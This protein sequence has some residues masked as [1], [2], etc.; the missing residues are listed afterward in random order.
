MNLREYLRCELIHRA[1]RFAEPSA[2]IIAK[3]WNHK[4]FEIKRNLD[5]MTNESKNTLP[6]HL[7]LVLKIPLKNKMPKV[8]DDD[9]QRKE[10]DCLV[11]DLGL[12]CDEDVVVGHV[13]ISR[14]DGRSD[15]ACCISYSLVVDSK[16]RG[17]GFGRVLTE[18][19]EDR[20]RSLGLSYM[21]LS[22]NDK[23]KMDRFPLQKSKNYK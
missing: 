20:A 23:V 6:C 17:L 19:A 5:S 14:A 8:E 9:E 18:K 22:T 11:K 15:G 3:Q 7:A 13:K 21:Y 12:P 2:R 4:E 1:P 16:F 10:L